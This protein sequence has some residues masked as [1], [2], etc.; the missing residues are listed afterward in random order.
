MFDVQTYCLVLKLEP[1]RRKEGLVFDDPI[2][3]YPE[4][5]S[6]STIFPYTDP[7]EGFA[8]LVG[9]MAKVMILATYDP[10]F[11]VLWNSLEWE[12]LKCNVENIT[13]S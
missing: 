12:F 5:L 13:V 8:I 9:Y 11:S 7:K 6:A 3:G 1:H 4:Q 10:H 2:R